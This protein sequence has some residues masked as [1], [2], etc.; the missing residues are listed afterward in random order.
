MHGGARRSVLAFSM[1]LMFALSSWAINM[2]APTTLAPEAEVSSTPVNTT[3]L[4]AV[5]SPGGI[6]AGLTAEIPVGHA[7]TE[8]DLSLEPNVLNHPDG[9]SLSSETQ[10]NA[11]GAHLDMVDVNKTDGIQL[12]PRE[13][14]WDFET[15]PS[16][17]PQ[18]WSLGTGWLWGYDSCLGQSGGVHG[19]TKAIY[20]YNCNYPNGIPSSG[21]FA[22]SPVIDC[23]GCSGTWKLKYWKRL[24]I[25]S[26][27]YDD[28]QV[29]VKDQNGNWQTAWDW[30]SYSTNP[31]TWSHASHDISQWATGNSQLQVRF[32]LGRTDGSVTYTG[33]NVDDVSI[34]P[35]QG[36]GGGESGNWTSA[37]FGPGIVGDFG[38]PGSQHGIVSIDATV[39]TGADLRMTIVDGVSMTPLPGYQDLPATWVDLGAIDATQHPTL[40]ILLYLGLGSSNTGPIVHSVNINGRLGSA[41]AAN[42]VDAGWTMSGTSWNGDVV[43]GSGTFTSP[44]FTPRRPT[45]E[46]RVDLDLDSGSPDV[47]IRVNGGAWQT[48]ASTLTY[49]DGD[50]I[51]TV[52]LR[53]DGRGSNFAL[54]GYEI[55]LVGAH[56]PRTPA[57]DVGLDGWSEWTA[58]HTGLGAWGWQDRLLDGS[59]SRDFLFSTPGSQQVGMLLP[60]A[61]L[62]QFRFDI[63]PQS[64]IGDVEVD[65]SIQGQ[66]AVNMTRTMGTSSEAFNLDTTQLSAL[67]DALANSTP[68][69][70]VDGG[71]SYAMIT[72][73][74]AADFGELRLGGLN[75]IHDTRL[76]ISAGPGSA[77]VRAVN[78]QIINGVEE[79]GH[80]QV[81]LP[82]RMDAAGAVRATIT[83]LSATNSVQTPD[84]WAVNAP[85]PTL[86]PSHQWI[87]IHSN[88]TWTEGT[89]AFVEFNFYGSDERL[90]WRFPTDCTEPMQI[91]GYPGQPTSGQHIEFHPDESTTCDQDD[92]N[93]TLSH[94]VRLR[95]LPTLGDQ[96]MVHMSM[97][98]VMVS[99][100]ESYPQQQLL[101]GGNGAMGFE[102]DVEIKF[103]NVFNEAGHQVPTSMSYLKS[104][105]PIRI[106]V[107][108]GFENLT[109]MNLGPRTDAVLVA[110]LEN[111]VEILNTTT[112]TE[113]QAVFE[114][115]TPTGTSEVNYTVN[116]TPLLGQE[117]YTS[118]P[119]SR[120][121]TVDSLS[122]QVID[123]S[124]AK[125]DHRTPS[126]AQAVRIEVH[127]Q[128]V[129]PTNL[130]LMLWKEWADDADGDGTPDADEF[131]EVALSIPSNLS[132]GRGNYTVH[133]DDTA[134][135]EGD[136]VAGY[137]VGAD[138]AGNL[139]VDGGS[140]E[141]DDQ[142]FTYQLR[143][144]G[145][146][147]LSGNAGFVGE[148]DGRLPW[149]HPTLQYEF[150]A[151]VVEPNGWSDIA[152]LSLMLASNSI[153]DLLEVHW[154]AETGRCTSESPNLHVIRCGM[155]AASGELT[156]FNPDLEFF[157][158][159]TLDWDLPDEGD[160]RREPSIE[161][162]D[163]AGQG[164]WLSFPT[165]RWR[166]STDIGIVADSIV[167]E[168]GDGIR[169][170]EGAWVA[171]AS[172]LG[173]EGEIAFQPSGLA[174]AEPLDIRILL[175][176]E[177]SLVNTTDGRFEATLRSP[178]QTGSHPL[179]MEFAS[180]PEAAE[181]VTASEAVMR[182]IVVDPIGPEPIEVLAPRDGA[183][184]ALADLSA[185]DIEVRFKE[186]EKIDPDSLLLHWKVARGTDSSVTP[187]AHGEV[188]L[189]IPNGNLAGQSIIGQITLD[190]AS[191]IPAPAYADP[192]SL[193]I[194]F[195]GRDMAG[196]PMEPV[197]SGNSEGDPFATWSIEHLSPEFIIEDADIALSRG[198][199][200]ELGDA[201]MVTLG[202]R[203][204]G[205]VHGTAEVMLYVQNLDDDKV[206]LTTVPLRIDVGMG[207]RTLENIDWTPTEVGRQWIV[208]EMDGGVV[209]VGPT[210]HVTEAAGGGL[211]SNVFGDVPA[212]WIFMFVALLGM[213]GAVLLLA[214]RS[215]GT[216]GY[217]Y[218]E[219]EDYWDEDED[220]DETLHP[221]T[222]EAEL[223]ASFGRPAEYPLAFTDDVVQ[224][225][226]A[227]HG[228]TDGEG[229]L[230][231]ARGFDKDGN[232]YL[233]EAE[234]NQAAASFVA[235]AGLTAAQATPAKPALDPAT[236]TPEQLEWYEQAKQWG[237]YYDE[238]GTWIP[239]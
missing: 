73:D 153:E 208:V 20:T 29:H 197:P 70:V 62:T 94:M 167:L 34:E 89:P 130:A 85:T 68:M 205:E 115:N 111:G 19:G 236:M 63:T 181:D 48:M 72:I 213:L 122:P 24:G 28:A 235:A 227:K 204:V 21:Y 77:L 216:R 143:S 15:G 4:L 50:P 170:S 86:T 191:E 196:N 81:P 41:L 40:R 203:N 121:F 163:R 112:L 231:H 60:M 157:I 120:N 95:F 116:V 147:S 144:D 2:P 158:E 74:V 67:N 45:G 184:L 124:I 225:V 46:V 26:Y 8:L 233:K 207:E 199:E 64:Y 134:G 200:V 9:F 54:T 35:D 87:E 37:R 91:P 239:L 104:S 186:L 92:V 209:A 223:A 159:Y 128:P 131:V 164:A 127:D 178:A 79:N 198:G 133:V 11:S 107:D 140:A 47:E 97:T 149:A 138:P 162:T 76:D 106:E 102:D 30:T 195:T 22:T 188:L 118:I 39:P 25:E 126:P 185:L 150:T 174:P 228:I 42:P 109:H 146:P 221:A 176:G 1:V 93:Q 160:L 192:L 232:G 75:A 14:R 237:G 5:H 169:S 183:E 168:V 182:W 43:S 10:W 61:G 16:N 78:T 103:W 193:H 56:M 27:Y 6:D 151:H 148:E 117:F 166:F 161:V 96:H 44:E 71:L 31:S 3:A 119:M 137:V 219:T 23:G 98:L 7:L 82:I 105:S 135:D 210:V 173:L 80:V 53:V 101:Y 59:T 226:I 172:P 202:V 83:T 155:R 201:I 51:H 194:W 108:L 189:T 187:H 69:H 220:E 206:P 49:T 84:I 180:L 217:S 211:L 90:T 57:L 17:A 171:P 177:E 165:L 129:L 66:S 88:H 224:S 214:L 18:G 222:N 12:L 125:W 152:D 156:P 141:T 114:F 136:L 218:D 33:W 113:G 215:G 32:K 234:L 142:L 55:D 175:D 139:V 13:F 52:Q 123:C 154:S 99:G 190:L 65:L 179:T 229:F 110:L 238:S 145:A 230:Q 58:N 212:M 38:T 36:A 100:Y 132:R